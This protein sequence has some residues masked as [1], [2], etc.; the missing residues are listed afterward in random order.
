MAFYNKNLTPAE[1]HYH[2]TDRELMAVYLAYMKWR[3]YLHGNVCH[4][5][6]DQEPLTYIFILPHLNAPQDPWL[7]RL[8][9]LDLK[10]HYVLGKENVAA[11]V[12]SH[13]G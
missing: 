12:L 7:E 5:Y 13:Y 4:V 11:D 2:V 6:T 9:E 3:H 1:S 8:A 10:V